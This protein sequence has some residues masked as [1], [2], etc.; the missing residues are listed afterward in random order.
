MSIVNTIPFRD[1]MIVSVLGQ[2]STT[3]VFDANAPKLQVLDVWTIQRAVGESSDT[4]SVDNGTDADAI[5]D[6]MLVDETAADKEILRALTIDDDHATIVEGGTLRV[7]W[8]AGDS[9]ADV[10]ILCQLLH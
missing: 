3:T 5:T 7:R 9:D 1:L 8:N 4:L 2:T 10:F 6:L